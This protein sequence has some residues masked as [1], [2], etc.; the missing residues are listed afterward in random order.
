MTGDL[1]QFVDSLL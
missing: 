1:L